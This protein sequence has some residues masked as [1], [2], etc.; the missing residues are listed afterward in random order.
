MNSVHAKI[1]IRAVAH[2]HID[3]LQVMDNILDAEIVASGL[4]RHRLS[5]LSERA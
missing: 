3:V 1:A 2:S 5:V 4:E